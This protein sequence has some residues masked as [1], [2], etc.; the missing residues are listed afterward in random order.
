MYSIKFT[1]FLEFFSM[2]LYNAF[3]KDILS[4]H[5]GIYPVDSGRNNS[6]ENNGKESWIHSICEVTH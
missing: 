2:Y 6:I 4:Y 3:T 5:Y 1:S